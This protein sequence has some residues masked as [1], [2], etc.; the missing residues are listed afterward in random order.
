MGTVDPDEL[1]QRLKAAFTE[2]D[3]ARDNLW[4][5]SEAVSTVAFAGQ[6]VYEL[7]SDLSEWLGAG[8]CPPEAMDKGTSRYG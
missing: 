5:D 2:L 7:G 6:R 1:Y 3:E 8:G 4:A